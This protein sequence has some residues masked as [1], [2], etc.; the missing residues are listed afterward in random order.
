MSTF[1]AK[2]VREFEVGIEAETLEFADI[3][4]RRIIAEMPEGTVRLI[5]VAAE[6]EPNVADDVTVKR[7]LN[8]VQ[9]PGGID[10]IPVGA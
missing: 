9:F 7:E 1:L 8:R 6:G 10:D 5:S 2:F 4:A 3:I